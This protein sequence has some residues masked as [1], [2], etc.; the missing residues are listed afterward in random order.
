MKLQHLCKDELLTFT[1]TIPSKCP[2]CGEEF[3]K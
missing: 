2:Y 1:G 3:K